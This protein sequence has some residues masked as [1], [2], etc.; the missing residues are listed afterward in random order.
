MRTSTCIDQSLA[1]TLA[2]LMDGNFLDVAAT[3]PHRVLAGAAITLGAATNYIQYS[4]LQYE[5]SRIEDLQ[6]QRELGIKALASKAVELEAA[7]CELSSEQASLVSVP[8]L[9]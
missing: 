1:Q 9:P 6:S 4:S 3:A 7:L 2:T 5:A 8:P